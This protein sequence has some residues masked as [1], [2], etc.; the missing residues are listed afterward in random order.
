MRGSDITRKIV[1]FDIKKGQGIV[2]STNKVLKGDLYP[3]L[4]LLVRPQNKSN[5]S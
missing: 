1:E 3:N 4:V 5:F 2:V